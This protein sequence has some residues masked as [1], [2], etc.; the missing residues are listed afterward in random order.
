MYD[1][2]CL[3]ITPK[4]F[5]SNPRRLKELSP[6]RRSLI[7]RILQ[8]NCKDPEVIKKVVYHWP[9]IIRVVNSP[10]RSLISD[11]IKITPWAFFHLQE[12]H[13]DEYAAIALVNSYPHFIEAIERPTMNVQ[14]RAVQADPNSIIHIKNPCKEVQLVAVDRDPEMIYKIKQPTLDTIRKVI[15]KNPKMTHQILIRTGDRL[16]KVAADIDY[17]LFKAFLNPIDD[18]NPAERTDMRNLILRT[19]ESNPSYFK[20]I[21]E[22]IIE[23]RDFVYNVIHAHLQEHPEDLEVLME[24]Y[25]TFDLISFVAEKDDAVVHSQLLKRL[26]E[27]EKL[28]LLN[29]FPSLKRII[30]EATISHARSELV[31]YRF[32]HKQ[33]LIKDHEVPSHLRSKI[34]DRFKSKKLNRIVI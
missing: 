5:R 8:D 12:F 1:L 24:D 18:Y 25:W 21:N 31:S 3:E 7:N 16:A 11:C 15:L 9:K 30:V 13:Q 28:K 23:D 2:S 29:K 17:E 6:E 19:L 33:G 27:D 20:A 14:V 34:V 22:A 4:D 32:L 26:N 10:N